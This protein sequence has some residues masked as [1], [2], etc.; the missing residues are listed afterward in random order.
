MGYNLIIGLF[1]VGITVSIQ[2]HGTNFW[3]RKIFDK[4]FNLD[5]DKFRRKTVRLLIGTSFY[6]VVINAFQAFLWGVLYYALPHITN[7]ETLEKAVYFSLVTYTTLGYG[8]ITISSDYRI[9]S[10]IEAMN[11]ILLIGWSTTLMFSTMQY[12]LKRT[13]KR[14]I[15]DKEV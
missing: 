12:I 14:E 2:A 15:S 7:L 1:M 3:R 13:S 11:G 8:D 10:G 6:L 4:Y 9:L 5:Y